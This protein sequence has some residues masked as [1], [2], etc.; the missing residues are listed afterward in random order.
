MGHIAPMEVVP[1]VRT[2]D[3]TSYNALKTNNV[4]VTTCAKEQSRGH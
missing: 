1:C 2:F 4:K 3:I